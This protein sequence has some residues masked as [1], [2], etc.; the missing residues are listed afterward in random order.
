[1]NSKRRLVGGAITAL[2]LVAV[3]LA[4]L[5]T[6]ASRTEAFAVV[7]HVHHRRGVGGGAGDGGATT[8]DASSR[9][10]RLFFLGTRPRLS[11]ANPSSTTLFLSSRLRTHESEETDSPPSSLSTLEGVLVQYGYGRRLMKISPSELPV[12]AEVYVNGTARLARIVEIHTDGATSSSG[13]SG[14]GFD[15]KVTVE[16]FP[17]NA[18]MAVDFK[19]I[20]TILKDIVTMRPA[21]AITSAPSAMPAPSVVERTL[22]Q[23]Y[24]SYV[25]RGRDLHKGGLSKKQVGS[26]VEQFPPDQQPYVDQILRHALKAGSGL[27][28][29]VDAS[30]VR[31]A[32]F[33]GGRGNSKSRGS[34]DTT[35]TALTQTRIALDVLSRD[36]ANGRGR[37]KRWPCTAVARTPSDGLCF[38][39]GGWVVVDRNVRAGSEAR[40][41]AAGELRTSGATWT[42]ADL[43]IA[44]RLECLAMGEALSSSS[45]VV[46]AA[47]SSRSRQRLPVSPWTVPELP[48]SLERDVRETLRAMNL[49]ATPGGAKEALV[50]VGRWMGTG[51]LSLI[52]PWSKDV[53]RNKPV[54]SWPRPCPIP[55]QCIL[56]INLSM[57]RLVWSVVEGGGLVLGTEVVRAR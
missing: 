44:Q 39:N 38:L 6:T 15:P 36:A 21:E 54:H 17:G 5:I 28:R 12:L 1:M 10:G 22:D 47:S 8:T 2:G 11:A 33:P 43:R 49:P 37:F 29:L 52:E 18:S 51:D 34:P 31:T 56:T 7:D 46:E 57:D 23:L 13:A 55:T 16:T 42:P 20:T 45:S 30:I 41:F 9:G 25:G 35:T 3:E 19:Q 14:P 48:T 26:V 32:L 40:Q 53:V 24:H 50:R 27:S 4:L